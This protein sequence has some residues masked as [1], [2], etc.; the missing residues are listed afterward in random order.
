MDLTKSKGAVA[1]DATGKKATSPGLLSVDAPG[2]APAA[3]R[4]SYHSKLSEQLANLDVGA[5]KLD[6]KLEDLEE[7]RELGA[8]NGGTV[9][10]VKHLPTQTTMAKKVGFFITRLLVRRVY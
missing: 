5:D 9:K 7:F 2:S 4:T 8:G 1:D 6:L 3:R 10:L